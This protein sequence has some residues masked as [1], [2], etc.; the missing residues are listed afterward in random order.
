VPGGWQSDVAANQRA[1]AWHMHGQHA[2]GKTEGMGPLQHLARQGY[3]VTLS[4]MQLQLRILKE[5][6]KCEKL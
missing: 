4:Y 1:R 3:T 5:V 6:C 2:S